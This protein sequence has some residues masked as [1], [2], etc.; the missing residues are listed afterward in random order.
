MARK[1]LKRW[2]PDASTF[3]KTPA[4]RFM[5]TLLHDPNLFHLNRHSVSVAVF[6][7]VFVAFLPILGQMPLAAF[8]AILFRCNMPIAVAI[9]WIS[10]PLTFPA[11]IY[12]TYEVGR[13]VLSSPPA[14]FS[15]EL[16]WRWLS[17]D[18]PLIWQPLL[19]GSILTGLVLGFIAY[20]GMQ[21]FWYWS[22]MRNWGIRKEKRL[23]KAKLLKK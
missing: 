9:C 7:G 18:F 19:T 11:I 4:L 13:W 23:K 8:L 15:I 14:K 2:L 3:K 22:V 12:C 20:L 6:T 1:L 16:S 17:E 21:G 5:G 10:N